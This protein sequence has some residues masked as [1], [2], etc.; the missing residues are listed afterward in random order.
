MRTLDAATTSTN[1]FH[2]ARIVLV[3]GRLNLALLCG[4]YSSSS[5]PPPSL[6]GLLC[7]LGLC[8]LGPGFRPA[9]SCSRIRRG[10]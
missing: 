4:R 8:L 10:P 7:R 9:L 1:S 3:E 5:L 6:S 2:T